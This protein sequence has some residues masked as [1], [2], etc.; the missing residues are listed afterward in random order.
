MDK[1]SK[2]VSMVETK[3]TSLKEDFDTRVHTVNTVLDNHAR[4][5][6]DFESKPE[7]EVPRYETEISEHSFKIKELDTNM[8]KV[9]TSMQE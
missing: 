7:I 3:L 9:R 6:E 1:N 8:G 5:L 2:I 4:R